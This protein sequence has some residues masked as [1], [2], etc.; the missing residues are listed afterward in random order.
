[1]IIDKYNVPLKIVMNNY[2][3]TFTNKSGFGIK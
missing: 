2:N 1:M 3:Q